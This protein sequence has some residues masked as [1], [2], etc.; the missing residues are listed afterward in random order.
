MQRGVRP[1]L[2][3]IETRFILGVD[4]VT[5][6]TSDVTEEIVAP[7]PPEEP[8]R[9][10]PAKPFA[11]AILIVTVLIA[12]WYAASDRY[13]PSTSRAVVSANVVQIASRVPGR[14]TDIMVRDNEIVPSGSVLFQIDERP[15][16]IAAERARVQLEQAAQTLDASSAQLTATYAQV[17][18]ARAALE[19]V[20]SENARAEVL[21]ERGILA[22]AGLDT[23]RTQVANAEA[24]LA[25]AEAQ[26]DSAERSLGVVGSENPSVRAAQ[27][28]LEQAE[29]DL[30]STTVTAP[31]RGVVTNLRLAPGQFVGAGQPALTFI[32]DEGVWITA[33]LRENQLVE[34]DAGDRVT[35]IFDA[36]PGQIFEGTVESLGW[37]IN[38]G[39]SEAGGLPVN[40][41]ST[42]WFEPARRMPVRVELDGG[43]D[44]W[45]RKARVGGNVSIVV[46]S[47]GG[48]IVSTLASGLQRVQS[49]LTALY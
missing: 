23:S 33:D 25:A 40:A 47:T 24:G 16:A 4:Q 3:G 27:L 19:N 21:A 31:R 44:A 17:A 20:R 10:N 41:S 34:V 7:E 29:F 28:A 39:R 5:D 8:R 37:G 32:E 14:V 35:M 46:H 45:P 1:R 18:Q 13:A 26:A 36:A 22:E 15:F 30:L 6:I 11:I 38:P 2:H 9:G 43:M 49:W 12:G 42:Q 48:G